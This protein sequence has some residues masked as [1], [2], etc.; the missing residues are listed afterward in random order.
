MIFEIIIL[1]TFAHGL[2]FCL[3]LVLTLIHSLDLNA[4]LMMKS[5]SPQ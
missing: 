4:N 2:L 3:N 5:M 1:F